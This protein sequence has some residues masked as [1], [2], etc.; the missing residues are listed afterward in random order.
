M[1]RFYM[2]TQLVNKIRVSGPESRA[3]R[4]NWGMI[5]A[6]DL[7]LQQSWISNLEPT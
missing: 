1:R 5:D 6:I 4:Q 3:F 7:R 2:K